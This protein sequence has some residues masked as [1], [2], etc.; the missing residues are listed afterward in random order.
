[1][2]FAILFVGLLFLCGSALKQKADAVSYLYAGKEAYL[3]RLKESHNDHFL[4]LNDTFLLPTSP[5]LDSGNRRR[6]YR[7]VMEML[8]L[9]EKG[10]YPIKQPQLVLDPKT[11]HYM[12]DTALPYLYV[13]LDKIWHYYDKTADPYGER[14]GHGI[15]FVTEEEL[16]EMKQ[17]F[18]R[19]EKH[20]MLIQQAR[21]YME[22]ELEKRMDKLYG[23]YWRK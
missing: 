18:V 12:A 4:F 6:P 22:R 5:L 11:E 19:V 21:E 1:M 13:P 17:G 15:A 9:V 3:Q 2:G 8:E 14:R 7:Q 20:K 16:E 10:Y 23:E